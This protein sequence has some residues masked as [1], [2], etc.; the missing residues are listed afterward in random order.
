MPPQYKFVE[1]T[2]VTDETI[3][4]CVNEWV[5]LGWHLE[6]IRFVL[7]EHSKRP[8]MAFVSFTRDANQAVADGEPPRRPPP[9]VKPDPPGEPAVIVNEHD[10]D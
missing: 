3:E 1:L 8:G 5:Q 10:V 4:A 7:G 6:G 2:P 9:L